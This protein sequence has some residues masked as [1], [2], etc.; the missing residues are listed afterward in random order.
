MPIYYITTNSNKFENA[1]AILAQHDILIEQRALDIDE[2]QRADA[3]EIAIIKAQR[4]FAEL[5]QPLFVN[6]ATWMI[7]SLKGFPGPFMKYINQ[8][9]EPSDFINLMQ[10]KSDR[11]VILRDTIVYVDHAGYKVFTSDHEGVVLDT[12]ASFPYTHPSE[13]VFSLSPNTVSIAEARA[14]GESLATKEITVWNDFA[15]W[16]KGRGE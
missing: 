11:R 2:P 13:A 14:R 8:W 4:A 10:G 16:L 7:P 1:R 9:F 5:Q 12:V 15:T 6:D 3:L